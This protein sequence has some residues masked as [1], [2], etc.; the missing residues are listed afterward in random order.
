MKKSTSALSFILLQSL[1]LNV[2]IKKPHEKDT[3]LPYAY[4]T[5]FRFKYCCPQCLG[6]AYIE[7]LRVDAH[8]PPKEIKT[9][10]K[11]FFC[12]HSLCNIKVLDLFVILKQLTDS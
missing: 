2:L 1:R 10:L 12:H 4:F 9:G 5:H 3:S 8:D 7:E 6:S 11:P